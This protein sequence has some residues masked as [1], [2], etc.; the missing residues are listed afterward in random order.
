MIDLLNLKPNIP[1][2]DLENYIIGFYGE[3]A[4]GKTRFLANLP[5]TLIIATE[6]G[7]TTIPNCMAVP[8]KSWTDFLAVTSQLCSKSELREKYTY[9]GIDSMTALVALTIDYV[10][11]TNGISSLADLPY[12]KAYSLVYDGIIKQLR[13]L[14]KHFSIVFVAHAI[15]KRDEE[16][17]E[18]KYATL[19]CP[20][21]IT[22]FIKQNCDL[23]AYLYRPRDGSALSV[24]KTRPS[25]Y[26]IAKS[27]FTKLPETIAFSPETVMEEIAKAVE[28][29]VKEAGMEVAKGRRKVEETK[30][31]SVQDFNGLKTKLIEEGQKFLEEYPDYVETLK[32]IIKNILG[33]KSLSDTQINDHPAL[34]VLENEFKNLFQKV[35]KTNVEQKPIKREVK[36]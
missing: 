8:V 21:K 27:R 18:I 20:D 2:A 34:L 6:I 33:S 7:Y 24:A 17:E 35:Q 4:S 9:L 13:R 11:E 30:E 32:G 23:L 36:E 29:E 25:Q 3:S 26:W 15:V 31:V 5:K 16:D 22:E 19:S 14:L 1:S 28:M 12:G 10:L